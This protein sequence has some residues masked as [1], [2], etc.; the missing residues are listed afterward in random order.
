M[1]KEKFRIYLKVEKQCAV[2]TLRA[3]L[4]DL[5]ELATYLQG[6]RQLDVFEEAGVRALV[7]RDLRGWMGHL[8]ENGLS[9][10]SIARKLS[11]AKSYFAFLQRSGC[12]ENNP[13]LRVKL[14]QFE[15]R[16]PAFLKETETESLLDGIVFPDTFEGLRDKCLLELLYGCGL[17]RA[18]VLS[19]KPEDI[20]LYNRSLRVRGKGGKDRILPFGKHVALAIQVYLDRADAESQSLKRSFFITRTGKPAYPNM[21]YRI[22][23]KY[24]SQVSSLT[25]QSPHVMRHTFATHLL[26]RGADLNAIKELLGHASL[27]ATQVY[28]HNT[29]SKLK[30]VHKQAHPRAFTSNSNES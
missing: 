9:A 23:Q 25:Q 12:I 16:L 3:Y 8:R 19:L 24:L 4:D 11:A 20:D 21:V 6:L 1:L 28:T 5:D 15:R 30:S 7:H 17:R 10:R 26:D 14:P 2:H 22:V 29:I 13:A 18:E 27:A